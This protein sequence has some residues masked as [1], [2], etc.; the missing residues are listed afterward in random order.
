[1]GSSGVHRNTNPAT[2]EAAP[3]LLEV[4]SDLLDHL[5]TRVVIPL[6]R[7]DRAPTIARLAP[8]ITFEGEKLLLMAPQLRGRPMRQPGAGRRQFAEN[9]DAVMAALD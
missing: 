8:E 2:S 5:A 1:M 6:F 4:Q 3:Y 9:R 7:A